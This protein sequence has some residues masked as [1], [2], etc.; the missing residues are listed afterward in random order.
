MLMKRLVKKAEEG[1]MCACVCSLKNRLAQM[2]MKMRGC[3][4][5]RGAGGRWPEKMKS[6]FRLLEPVVLVVVVV[7]LVE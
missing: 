3:R 1:T 6:Q 5:A 4:S 2:T 7:E